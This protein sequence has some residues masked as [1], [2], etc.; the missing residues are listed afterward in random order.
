MLPALHA[1]YCD[2]VVAYGR[3]A[4]FCMCDG[5]SRRASLWATSSTNQTR[6]GISGDIHV[7]ARPAIYQ[8]KEENRESD[9][10]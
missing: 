9:T 8:P 2:R 4:V 5:T 3:S 1:V 6:G 10:S 7:N